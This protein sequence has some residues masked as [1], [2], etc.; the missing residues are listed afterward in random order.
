VPDVWAVHVIDAFPGFSG[1]MTSAVTDFKGD[2]R[3]DVAMTPM[4]NDGNLV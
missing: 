2:G 3:V 1:D 4:Y